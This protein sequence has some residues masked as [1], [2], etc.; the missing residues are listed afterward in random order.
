VARRSRS[1]M[2]R[3][4]LSM[5]LVVSPFAESTRVPHDHG[6]AWLQE[7]AFAYSYR[8]RSRIYLWVIRNRAKV[9]KKVD[10]HNCGKVGTKQD[11]KVGARWEGPLLHDD[12]KV[13]ASEVA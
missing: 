12:A 2:A 5:S 7:R 11:W 1:A 3:L 9:H 8:G 6:M 10:A 13:V 4:E